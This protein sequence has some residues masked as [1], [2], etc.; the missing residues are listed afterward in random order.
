LLTDKSCHNA[1]SCQHYNTKF[2][3]RER[4]V[5]TTHSRKKEIK[6]ERKER[7]ERKKEREE[8]KEPK[9]ER[10]ESKK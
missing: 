6:K 1:F 2:R 7:K 5:A 10:K 4:N 9:K 3:E 8:R